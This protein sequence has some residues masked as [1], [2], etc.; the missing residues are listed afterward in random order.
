MEK[1]QRISKVPG[2]TV[3]SDLDTYKYTHMEILKTISSP[4]GIVAYLDPES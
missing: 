2:D 1:K 4:V 3:H